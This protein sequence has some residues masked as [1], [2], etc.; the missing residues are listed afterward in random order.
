VRTMTL[1]ASIF[2]WRFFAYIRLTMTAN[3]RPIVKQLS[4][5]AGAAA[6]R[7]VNKR[8]AIGPYS[9]A[10][11]RGA[12]GA[13]NGNSR[14]AKFIKA[15]EAM[16]IEHC[17]GNP[18]LVQRAL[19]TRAARLAC[20]LELWD[21][22]TLPNGGACSAVGHNTYIAWTNALARVLARIGLQSTAAPG[23][24]LNQHLADLAS[25]EEAA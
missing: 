3:R 12:V 22:K 21:E 23:K 11:Y 5:P 13:L 2:V 8:D 6:A 14:Y 24:T 19:I 18:S 1:D 16:L 4:P 15:Y 9:R 25:D 17:G 20:H 10:L 7:P